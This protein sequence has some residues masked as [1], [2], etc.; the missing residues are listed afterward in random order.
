MTVPSLIGFETFEMHYLAT[1]GRRPDHEGRCSALRRSN[2]RGTP[3]LSSVQ[4][5]RILP[6]ATRWLLGDPNFA[7]ATVDFTGRSSFQACDELV[8]DKV[9][10]R[11]ICCRYAC[12][13]RLHTC[14]CFFHQ[15]VVGGLRPGRG[16][17]EN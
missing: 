11:R 10:E 4:P 16:R 1:V 14:V 5:V 6:D 15:A 2:L 13:R 3:G 17:A 9:V 12:A 7:L 8:L